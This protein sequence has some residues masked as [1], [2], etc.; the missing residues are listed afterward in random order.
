MLPIADMRSF[1]DFTG[2]VTGL[3]C[4]DSNGYI[5]SISLDRYLRVHDI[6]SRNLIGKASLSMKGCFARTFTFIVALNR[7]T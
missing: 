3:A 2:G 5:A 4:G 6:Q 1:V 7:L